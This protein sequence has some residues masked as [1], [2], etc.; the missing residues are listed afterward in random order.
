MLRAVLEAVFLG[1]SR[2]AFCGEWMLFD[3]LPKATAPGFWF[4]A[5]ALELR[6]WNM[7]ALKDC[8]VQ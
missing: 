1:I 6:V 8:D 4:I 5:K 7:M 3:L 2:M